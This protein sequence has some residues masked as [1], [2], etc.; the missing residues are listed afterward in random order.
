MPDRGEERCG[1]AVA[2]RREHLRGVY[3]GAGLT[4]LVSNADGSTT[5]LLTYPRNL[6]AGGVSFLSGSALPVGTRCTVQ[7][8]TA[9]GRRVQA[10]GTVRWST[11]VIGRIHRVG[12]AFDR[13]LDEESVA[14]LMC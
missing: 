2:S 12:V 6:S 14:L 5:S 9:S 13:E 1:A 3:A 4:I 10:P 7:F 8:V 11:P